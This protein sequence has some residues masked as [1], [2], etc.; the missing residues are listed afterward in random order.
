MSLIDD[1]LRKLEQKGRKEWKA[2]DTARRTNHRAL[3]KAGVR[4][5]PLRAERENNL[6]GE[7]F[8]LAKAERL[9]CAASR[10]S[11]ESVM[12]GSGRGARSGWL[13]WYSDGPMH[14]SPHLEF[15]A[16]NGGCMKRDP[17]A[18]SSSAASQFRGR[19]RVR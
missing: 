9:A 16:R 3:L 7:V 2:W 5:R 17:L 4:S 18:R 1:R 10:R 12:I 6:I 13:L 19:G 14:A 8:S 11:G 15:M